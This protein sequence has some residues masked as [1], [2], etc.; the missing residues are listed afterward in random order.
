M[1]G[2]RS[3]ITGWGDYDVNTFKF[4]ILIIKHI[5]IKFLK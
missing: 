1:P 3:Y 2:N 4:Y 5:I